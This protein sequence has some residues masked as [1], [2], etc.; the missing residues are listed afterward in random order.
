MH[1]GTYMT[2]IDP[3]GNPDYPY[4]QADNALA[5]RIQAG[6]YDGRLPGERALADEFG[7]TF[8]PS[9]TGGTD[10]ADQP[11]PPGPAPASR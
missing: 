9:E 5:A 2:G 11:S 4:R 7:G 3:T 6:H 10:H 8:P 1:Y